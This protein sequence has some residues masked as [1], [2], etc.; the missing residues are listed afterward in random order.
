MIGEHNLSG[1][2]HVVAVAAGKGGVG[3]S[4]LACNLALYFQRKGFKVGVMDA[5]L[6][7]PSLRKMLPEET[8]P[9]Q[10]AEIKERI[11][12][13]Q[14]RGIKLI[15]M[16]Y[17]ISADHPASVRAP[18]ANGVIK[19]F[20][21]LVEWGQLDFLFIDFPPGTGDIQLTLIQEG[22]LS[23]ALIVTTPQE[24]ALLDV[25]KATA[26]FRQ[27]QVPLIGIVENMSYFLAG[28]QSYFPFGEG[29]GERF[30]NENG[31]FFLGRIPID[32]LICQ[33]CDQGKSLFDE[34]A[35]SHA[36]SAFGPI[37]EKIQDQLEAFEKLKADH[38]TNFNLQWNT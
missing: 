10:H 2:R 1:V 6:Y 22:H 5:D 32:S 26:M 4:T 11:L 14:S 34:F 21:H 27:M 8:V 16:A 20:V 29:G 9:D 19:Q 33:C 7:G 17:F 25:L 15:S 38:L 31:L 18:I 13:A 23:G 3:K 37:G 24:I 30:A 35:A 12:P 28:E 36:A